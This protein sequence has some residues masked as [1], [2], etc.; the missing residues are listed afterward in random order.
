MGSFFYT[1]LIAS[2]L[3]SVCTVIAWGGFERYM[4]YIVSLIC[5]LLLLSPLRS[6]NID[7]LTSQLPEISLENSSEFGETLETL[8]EKEAERYISELVFS[9]F[10]IKA[11]YTDIKIDWESD[12]AVIESVSVAL[13]EAD[14]ENASKI[15][16]GLAEMLGGEVNVVGAS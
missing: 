6:I 8:S 13:S 11:V 2:V 16:K 5:A 4:K 10:G 7:K 14:F 1:L 12:P 3:G 9:E 15:K